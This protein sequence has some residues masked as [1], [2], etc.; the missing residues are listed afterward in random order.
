[1]NERIG[2]RAVAWQG[3][4]RSPAK[5]FSIFWLFSKHFA[6][7]YAYAEVKKYSRALLIHR[8]FR[9][10]SYLRITHTAR[11]GPQVPGPGP[12]PADFPSCFLLQASCRVPVEAT[13]A[14]LSRGGRGGRRAVGKR[15]VRF[16]NGPRHLMGT[17]NVTAFL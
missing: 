5:K 4:R 15:A 8:G 17:K 7:R 1:M 12:G 14:T 13:E 16:A 2:S 3:A 10:Q 6:A 9:G 11:L